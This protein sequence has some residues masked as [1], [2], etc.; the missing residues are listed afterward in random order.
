MYFSHVPSATLRRSRFLQTKDA[1][2][3]TLT[4]RRTKLHTHSNSPHLQNPSPNPDH[5]PDPDPDP[6]PKPQDFIT[7]FHGPKLHEALN[8]N[9]KAPFMA[10]SEK[11]SSLHLGSPSHGF[12]HFFKP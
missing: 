6:N 2:S 8:R 11:P 10:T 7:H 3:A 5:D 9:F 4:R 1:S 12:G